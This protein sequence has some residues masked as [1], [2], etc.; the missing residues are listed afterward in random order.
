MSLQLLRLAASNIR[1]EKRRSW[2]TVI[3]IFIGVAAV[4]GL[5]S[6]GQGLEESII[7]EFESIGADKIQVVAQDLTDDDIAV[8]E[9]TSG[10][11]IAG[12][13]LQLSRPIEYR[14]ETAFGLVVGVPTGDGLDLIR[15]VSS[16]GV[17][18]GRHLRHTDRTNIVITETIAEQTFDRDIGLRDTI[19]VND[20]D[21]R[22]VGI[23]EPSGPQFENWVFLPRDRM[24]D[25]YDRD[26][27]ELTR[28]VVRVQQGFEPE[29]VA[30]DIEAEMRRDRGLR[31]G[32]E[33]FTVFTMQG[34]LN[35]FQSILG[36]VQGIVLG[37]A[38]IS[39]LVGG[40]GI[41]NTMYTAVVERTKEIG[42][43]KAVGAQ[44]RQVLTIF[45]IESGIIG[46]IGGVL[47]VVLGA[48]LSIGAVYVARQFTSIPV[49]TAIT[50]QL[51][52]GALL[53]SAVVG[54]VSGVLPARKAAKM[55]P[56]DAL[57]HEGM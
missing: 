5:V 24:R 51:V 3:G 27:D 23:V 11:D 48:S 14:R 22:V 35:S 36:V 40:I 31:E 8:V 26:S 54:M 10:V 46:L 9:R 30:D 17:V 49:G 25:L 18:E 12:G 52:V 13:Y 6:L 32:D 44:D 45:L 33:D 53:F 19:A 47:G 34:V 2:L 50:P 15:E 43:M 29:D 1:N 39:L 57:R 56:V 21:F 55:E 4:V 42:I 37:I 7:G 41:M 20:Q 38:S 16:V 28:I